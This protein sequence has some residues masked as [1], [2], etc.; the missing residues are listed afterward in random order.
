[1]RITSKASYA[2]SA[3]IDLAL[4]PAG[5]FTSLQT[6]A[7][8]Q[9]ISVSY[10]EHLFAKLRRHGLVL[11][12]RGPGGG[13]ALARAAATISIAEIVNAV[14][15]KAQAPIDDANDEAGAANSMVAMLTPEALIAESLWA[16][17][18]LVLQ[19]ALQDI[20]LQSLAEP[21]RKVR[22][23]QQ[24]ASA[25]PRSPVLRRPKPVGQMP[26]VRVVVKSVF[27]LAELDV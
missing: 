13:Y 25:R 17:A 27:D 3:L 22:Q 20:D 26:H 23:S 21:H 9:Q 8:R 6:I 7:A 11:S 12:V 2:I 24:E 4:Q 10:L 19:H 15:Q 1:M 5:R 14:G 18:D 16:K